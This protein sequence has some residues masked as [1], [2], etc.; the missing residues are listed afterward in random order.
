MSLLQYSYESVSWLFNYLFA[1][2]DFFIHYYIEGVTKQTTKIY[3]TKDS[4]MASIISGT[5][6]KCHPNVRFNDFDAVCDDDKLFLT[7]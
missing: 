4:T 1:K 3:V 7:V 5:L 2:D 6:Q